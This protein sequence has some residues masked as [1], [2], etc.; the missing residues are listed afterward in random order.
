MMLFVLKII[1]LILIIFGILFNIQIY[2]LSS[3]IIFFSYNNI[4]MSVIL[5]HLFVGLVIFL[6]YYKT[7]KNLKNNIKST[8]LNKLSNFENKLDIESIDY[9]NDQLVIPINISDTKINID[10]IISNIKSNS[11]PEL[12]QNEFKYNTL[13]LSEIKEEKILYNESYF[14]I[15]QIDLNDNQNNIESNDFILIYKDE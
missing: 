2:K 14:E 13:E 7:K 15:K 8:E 6:I 3:T 4:V 5:F 12:N 1:I 11:L 9:N 10:D